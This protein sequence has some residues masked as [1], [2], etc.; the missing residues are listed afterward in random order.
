LTS[1]DLAGGGGSEV[2]RKRWRRRWEWLAVVLRRNRR[3]LQR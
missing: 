2:V 3:W 1:L